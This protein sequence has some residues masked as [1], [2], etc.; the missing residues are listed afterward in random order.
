MLRSSIGAFSKIDPRGL[1]GSSI[2]AFSKID[3]RG[4]TGL[5]G[6]RPVGPQGS[7]FEKAPMLDRE[8]WKWGILGFEARRRRGS[9]PKFPSFSIL[10]PAPPQ[11]PIT[12]RG[13]RR[14]RGRSRQAGP[15][16]RA[17]VTSTSHHGPGRA[18]EERSK[19]PGEAPPA[20]PGHPPSVTGS[21]RRA[22]ARGHQSIRSSWSVA[23]GEGTGS[24]ECV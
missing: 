4:L 12:G 3:P 21:G 13:A 5:R 7:I 17:P 16:L 22:Q 9:S 1:T 20:R 19:P 8:Y 6:R 24:A 11:P 15:L 14:R 18:Q 23:V 2:G 10:S